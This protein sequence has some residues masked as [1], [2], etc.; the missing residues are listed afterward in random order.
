MWAFSCTVEHGHCYQVLG[1]G[2][3][4]VNA[5]GR[6]LQRESDR[7]GEGGCGRRAGRQV[8]VVTSQWLLF[9]TGDLKGQKT[10]SLLGHLEWCG[11]EPFHLK[12]LT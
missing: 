6:V 12:S 1:E 4:P 7:K 8:D 2:G 10:G 3:Q 9:L 5:D 11:H